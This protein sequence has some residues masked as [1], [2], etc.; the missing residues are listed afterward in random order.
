MDDDEACGS[1]ATRADADAFL[2][3]SRESGMT[4]R[5][6]HVKGGF[7]EAESTLRGRY[8]TLTKKRE[9]RVRRPEWSETDVRL[10]EEGV[11]KLARPAPNSNG[12]ARYSSSRTVSERELATAKIPWKQVAE[13]IVNGGRTYHFGNSTCRKLWDELRASQKVKSGRR[14]GDVDIE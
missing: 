5:D 4:Y 11:R 7:T 6:I 10:L 8:R 3:K 12:T 9:E 2:I 13:Y 1:F 14:G